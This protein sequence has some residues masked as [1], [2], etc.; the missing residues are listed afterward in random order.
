MKTLLKLFFAFTSPLLILYFIKNE[1]GDV[2]IDF[3][4]QDQKLIKQAII[5]KFIKNN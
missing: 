4:Q 2:E 3:E 1:M 5:Y